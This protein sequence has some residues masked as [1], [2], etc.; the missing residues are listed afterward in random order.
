MEAAKQKLR[1][2][3]WWL[4]VFVITILVMAA[5][6]ITLRRE[7]RSLNVFHRSRRR[8]EIVEKYASALSIAL[9]FFDVQKCKDL[10]RT[11]VLISCY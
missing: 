1:G 10:Y 5:S 11:Y 9:L 3:R 4:T 6:Y 2:W 8:P 7:F